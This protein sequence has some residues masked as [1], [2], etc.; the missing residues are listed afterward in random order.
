M[1]GVLPS[2]EVPFDFRAFQT[3][4]LN[5]M[6]WGSVARAEELLNLDVENLV[7]PGSGLNS[8]VFGTAF[9]QNGY[10]R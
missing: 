6:Q 10:R 7:F 5:I 2:A 4:T 8:A 3:C 1:N 9:Y